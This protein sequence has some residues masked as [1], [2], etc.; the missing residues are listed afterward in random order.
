MLPVSVYQSNN[1]VTWKSYIQPNQNEKLTEREKEGKKSDT[2][3]LFT[4]R[5]KIRRCCFYMFDNA[6]DVNVLLRSFPAIIIEILHMRI[7]STKISLGDTIYEWDILPRILLYSFM[8]MYF[9]CTPNFLFECTSFGLFPLSTFWFFLFF[10]SLC[11][12]I[13]QEQRNMRI[14]KMV[15]R[16]CIRHIPTNTSQMWR[17]WL[18]L[19]FVYSACYYLNGGVYMHTSAPIHC[20]IFSFNRGGLLFHRVLVL[21][22]LVNA[23][24]SAS[25]FLP[26][27]SL[28]FCR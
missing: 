16:L 17:W 21:F 7:V 13:R 24:F 1:R 11:R 27:P 19:Q 18:W 8:W 26:P 28:S 9:W 22:M 5:P 25:L 3:A 2:T 14:P 12:W 10:Y 4:A 20:D 15:A 23:I 6:F